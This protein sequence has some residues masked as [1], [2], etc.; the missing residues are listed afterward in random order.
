MF[1]FECIGGRLDFSRW[2]DLEKRK[3]PSTCWVDTFA[4]RFPIDL[5]RLSLIAFHDA[6]KSLRSTEIFS[7]LGSLQLVILSMDITHFGL[8]NGPTCGWQV[9]LDWIPLESLKDRVS[10][11]VMSAAQY[12]AAC[13]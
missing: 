12:A 13:E 8:A 5:E 3:Q 1:F 6:P 10:A 9:C 2:L 11:T 7:S 4:I